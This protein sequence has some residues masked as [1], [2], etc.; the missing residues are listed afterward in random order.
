M[1]TSAIT[2]KL[3]QDI[4]IGNNIRNL[5]K[6]N[7]FTQEQVVAKLQLEGINMSRDFYAH[8][9]TGKYNIRISELATLKDYLKQNLMTFLLEFK[10]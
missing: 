4:N 3:K 5:R 10:K 8:I 2:Q 9:E 1:E 7:K 6:N